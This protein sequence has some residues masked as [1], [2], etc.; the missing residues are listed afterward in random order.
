MT[1]LSVLMK[2]KQ[3]FRFK[4]TNSSIIQYPTHYFRESKIQHPTTRVEGTLKYDPSISISVDAA[5]KLNLKGYSGFKNPYTR[6]PFVGLN[7][8]FDH[9]RVHV[10]NIGSLAHS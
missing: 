7:I 3:H 9:K 2:S 1:T 8:M 5:T 10:S 4:N 6:L